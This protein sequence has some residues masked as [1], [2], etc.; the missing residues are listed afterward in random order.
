MNHMQPQGVFLDNYT[1]MAD[2]PDHAPARHVYARLSGA[3]QPQMPPGGPYWSTA[4]LQTLAS[5]W[6][7]DGFLP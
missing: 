5:Q 3:E 1:Y 4:Q 7:I 2:Y 6:M